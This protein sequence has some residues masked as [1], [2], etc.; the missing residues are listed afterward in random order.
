M[1]YLLILLVNSVT[2]IYNFCDI[3]NPLENIEYVFYLVMYLFGCFKSH[4]IFV[5][6]LL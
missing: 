6:P 1:S 4:G 3:S 5:V 2:D